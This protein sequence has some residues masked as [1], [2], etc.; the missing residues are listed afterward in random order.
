MS[1]NAPLRQQAMPTLAQSDAVLDASSAQ[2]GRG[3]DVN[4]FLY[5][6]ES[7]RDYDPGPEL[8]KI[9]APLVA[10]NSADDLINPP[11]LGILEHEIVRVPNGRAIVVPF[12][13]TTRG[14]GTHTIAAVWDR[15]LAELLVAAPS[16]SGS[17]S[18]AIAER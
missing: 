14:H 9:R 3:L 12:G 10:V 15:Y 1:S 11:E 2:I 16:K 5:Q 7:S 13:P 6:I 8:E 18:A 17:A 4:D